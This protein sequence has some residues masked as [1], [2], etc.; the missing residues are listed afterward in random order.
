MNLCID[1]TYGAA[2]CIT[3][4]PFYSGGIIMSRLSPT[5]SRSHTKSL[6]R[7]RKE[8]ILH[9]GPLAQSSLGGSVFRA[10]SYGWALRFDRIVAIPCRSAASHAVY[11]PHCPVDSAKSEN[12]LISGLMPRAVPLFQQRVPESAHGSLI[13]LTLPPFPP[14]PNTLSLV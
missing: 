12:Q 4:A 14:F 5:T 9:R 8:R 13:N 1:S 6:W 2:V 10:R 7:P 11:A 3:R